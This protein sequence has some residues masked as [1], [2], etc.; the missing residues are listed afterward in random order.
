MQNRPELLQWLGDWAS[1]LSG[2]R[3]EYLE[4]ERVCAAA[5]RIAATLLARV[6]LLSASA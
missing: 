4:R 5:I 1:Y 3:S 6:S 2:L